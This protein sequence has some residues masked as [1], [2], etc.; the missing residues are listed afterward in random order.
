VT[1]SGGRALG[2]WSRLE[3]VMGW[4]PNTVGLIRKER[5]QYLSLP[6]EDPAGGLLSAGQEDRSHQT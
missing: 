3:E 6:C 5:D 4:D 1:V 2:K